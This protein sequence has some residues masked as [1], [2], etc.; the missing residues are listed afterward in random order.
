MNICDVIAIV[1]ITSLTVIQGTLPS[2]I[3]PPE[4]KRRGFSQ[5]TTGVV[6]AAYSI[7]FIIGALIPTN[8]LY[9]TL[10]RRKTS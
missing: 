1:L 5:S 7:G 8:Y 4:M 3:L 2:P 10:G 6:V 9:A